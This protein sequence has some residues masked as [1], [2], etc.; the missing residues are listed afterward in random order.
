LQA[1][2]ADEGRQVLG[3]GLD[4][5]LLERVVAKNASEHRL[6]PKELCEIK[7]LLTERVCRDPKGSRSVGVG[8]H[9]RTPRFA[10]PRDGHVWQPG[11][12][13]P[14]RRCSRRTPADLSW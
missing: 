7:R 1:A 11:R 12:S 13:V 9:R 10:A 14:V 6:P 2:L 3:N 5:L 4:L 8:A